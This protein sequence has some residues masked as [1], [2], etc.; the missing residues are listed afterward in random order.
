[1]TRNK[2][3]LR[4]G[5]HATSLSRRS[6]LGVMAGVATGLVLPHSMAKAASTPERTLS[7][8]HLHTGEKLSATYWVEGE[9]VD[10]SLHALNRLLRDHRSGESHTMDRG[11]FDLLFS[12]RESMDSSKP[13]HVISAY[14]SP[15]TNAMLSNKSRGVAKS[16]L[17]M[18]GKAIDIRLPGRDLQQ[19]HKAAR[20]LK[21]GGVGLYTKS[22]F[23]HVDTGRVRY[24]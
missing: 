3:I 16:S 23:V 13:F 11:L 20:A 14:R 1:M 4:G 2:R 19:L 6:F 5:H 15:K 8:L 9:Y 17:H 21:G 10:E 22:D 12:L 7:F 18:Q 24:W